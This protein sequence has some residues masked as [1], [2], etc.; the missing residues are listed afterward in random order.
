MKKEYERFEN[1]SIKELVN[2][3][4][5]LQKKNRKIV[6]SLA[7]NKEILAY[8]SSKIKA[9][10]DNKDDDENILEK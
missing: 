3:Y 6:E 2:E 10:F 1:M 9:E 5:K 8:L 4:E 7:Q